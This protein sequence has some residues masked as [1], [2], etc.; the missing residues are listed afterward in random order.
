M[1][2]TICWQA[3]TFAVV[4]LAIG[5]PLGV[6]AG[7]WAWQLTADTLGVHSGPMVPLA[8][9]AAAAV[10][11]VLAANLVAA[12]PGR[13]ASRLPPATALRSE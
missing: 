4:A 1:A 5:V 13:A 10:G 6:A 11:A 3:T 8:A 7:R 2:A 12:L 9:M